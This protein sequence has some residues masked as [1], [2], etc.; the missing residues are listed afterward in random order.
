MPDIDSD[1]NVRTDHLVRP[2]D[3]FDGVAIEFHHEIDIDTVIVFHDGGS[4]K[5]VKRD[6]IPTEQ[7]RIDDLFTGID[8]DYP[9]RPADRDGAGDDAAG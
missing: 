3:L 6:Y 7:Q 8:H 9:Q 4:Y 1:A 2:N 5:L